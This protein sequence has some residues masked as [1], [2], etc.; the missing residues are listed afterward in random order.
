MSTAL[1]RCLQLHSARSF[2]FKGYKNTWTEKNSGRI[3]IRIEKGYESD[4]NIVHVSFIYRE[5]V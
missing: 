3:K 1:H 4:I 5:N 2:L